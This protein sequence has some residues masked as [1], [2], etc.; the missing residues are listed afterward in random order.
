MYAVTSA[1]RR[2]AVALRDGSVLADPAEAA[3]H[4][5]LV[6][7]YRSRGVQNDEMRRLGAAMLAHKENVHYSFESSLAIMQQ[8]GGNDT[9]F[10]CMASA[11]HYH[12]GDSR[13]IALVNQLV[14]LHKPCPVKVPS[15]DRDALR[16]VLG[17]LKARLA[18]GDAIV[19]EGD[20]PLVDRVAAEQ[21][22]IEIRDLRCVE[23]TARKL[24]DAATFHYA[25][26]TPRLRAFLGMDG[27]S[28]GRLFKLQLAR[29]RDDRG[30][31][32]VPV[33]R[34]VSLDK[35]IAHHIATLRAA[36]GIAANSE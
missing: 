22:A 26:R 9:W 12:A 23:V 3:V 15:I 14:A 25:K 11:I 27:E 16:V 8:H 18:A 1:Y 36:L 17:Q 10:D 2:H 30:Y 20:R 35:A 29:S 5:A 21:H 6:T 4:E 7:L 33:L 13:F 32:I 19:V 24:D 28:F 31:E 34:R